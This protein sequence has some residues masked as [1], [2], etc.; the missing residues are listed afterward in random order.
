M[1]R[2][3]QAL[4]AWF[5]SADGSSM[6]LEDFRGRVVVL[7]VWAT[8]RWWPFCANMCNEFWTGQQGAGPSGASRDAGEIMTPIFA[9]GA[10]R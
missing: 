3:I 5:V 6:T 9:S 2:S 10:M 8:P 1:K 4:A 7:N